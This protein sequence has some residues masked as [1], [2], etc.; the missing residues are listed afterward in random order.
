M[1]PTIESRERQFLEWTPELVTRFW[2][3]FANSQEL[4]DL[5][6]TF[7]LGKEIANFLTYVTDLRDRR[8]L[9][10]GCGPGYLIAHLLQRGARVTGADYSP[11]SVKRVNERFTNHEGWE[12]AVHVS[13]GLIAAG[14]GQFDIITCIETIEHV[15]EAARQKMFFELRRALIPGG[16]V[17]FTTP[18]DENLHW[19]YV[20]CPKCDQLFHRW[21]HVCSWSKESLTKAL[22]GAGFSVDFCEGVN[23]S[24]WG[25]RE[26]K[27]LTD[28][29]L[30]DVIR[31][32]KYAYGRA[33]DRMFP[34][35]FPSGRAFRQLLSTNQPIHLVGIATKK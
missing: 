11:E 18:N 15:G 2:D 14:D 13:D 12:G 21:Q 17:M 28:F 10:Y 8:I 16:Y 34:R 31:S 26:R 30:G 19:N 20:F 33:A 3:Q 9:D 7:Q 4:Q 23:L 22:E 5:Y 24:N 32:L 1:G 29:S 27:K 25:Q 6:F 35:S